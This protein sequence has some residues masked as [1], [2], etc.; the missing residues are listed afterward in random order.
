MQIEL[1]KTDLINLVKG[2]YPYTT[3]Q[4]HWMVLGKGK[5]SDVFGMWIWNYLELKELSEYE[6]FQLYNLCKNTWPKHKV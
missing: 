1:D 4:N 2:V 5:Y 3:M 6:L